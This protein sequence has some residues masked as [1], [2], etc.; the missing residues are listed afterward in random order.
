MALREWPGCERS[1]IGAYDT[2]AGSYPYEFD[3]R[4]GT[5]GALS[6]ADG[7]RPLYS[8]ALTS[9]VSA[10]VGQPASLTVQA[11]DE[12]GAPI[13]Q[14]PITVT[15]GG[16]AS[17]SSLTGTTDSTGKAIVHYASSLAGV[18]LLQASA[19]V[20]GL[21]VVSNQ[22]TITWTVSAAPSVT[23]SGEQMLYLP[24]RGTYTATVTD[25]NAPTGGAI[26]VV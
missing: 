16:A 23:V 22:T 2:A 26:S 1:G 4:S 13:A 7:I 5:G 3:Y 11:L 18:A 17:Q 15:V 8:L 24:N 21:P 14:L 25:P 20:N 6:L 19:V 9:A 12:T 10:T